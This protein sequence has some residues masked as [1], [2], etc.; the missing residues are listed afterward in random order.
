VFKGKMFIE[1]LLVRGLNDNVEEL[2]LLNEAV[3]KIDPDGLQIHTVARPSMSGHADP[4]SETFLENAR[5]YFS[6]NSK[7]I[8]TFNQVSKA[9]Y[10]TET[11]MVESLLKIRPCH[12][13]E[14]LKSTGISKESLESLLRSLDE[15][16]SVKRIKFNDTTYYKIITNKKT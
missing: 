5:N 7:K 16:G 8:E 6:I 14:I 2:K 10:G 12:F 3:L 4:V 13:N 9:V 15:S 11:D 1:I